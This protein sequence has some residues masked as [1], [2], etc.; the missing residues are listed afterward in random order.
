MTLLVFSEFGRRVKENG[1]LGTDHGVA[2]PV[3]LVS[4]GI[5]GG[6]HGSHPSL[7]DLD[8]GDLKFSTDFR[9]IYATLLEG[10]LGV[11]SAPILGGSFEKL[12]LL[13]RVRRV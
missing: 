13:E 2:A 9:R 4:G 6:V 5:R 8:D 12:D 7:E 11:E 10:V 3:F 1:S